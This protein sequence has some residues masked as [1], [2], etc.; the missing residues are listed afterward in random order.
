MSESTILKEALSNAASAYLEAD[1]SFMAAANARQAALMIINELIVE[2][3]RSVGL[4]ACVI[5]R[6]YGLNY[7]INIQIVESSVQLTSAQDSARLSESPDPT[8]SGN[9]TDPYTAEGR[10]E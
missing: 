7:N 2:E 3:L 8:I 10:R 9:P 4:D 5:T 6:G 1:Q